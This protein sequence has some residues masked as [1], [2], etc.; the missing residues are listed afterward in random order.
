MMTK[1]FAA[2]FGDFRVSSTEAIEK[3]LRGFVGR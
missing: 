2:K 3:V 1:T